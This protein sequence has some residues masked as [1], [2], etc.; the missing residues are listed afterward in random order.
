MSGEFFICLK[1]VNNNKAS[2]VVYIEDDSFL[3]YNLSLISDAQNIP[4]SFGYPN[5]CI[6]IL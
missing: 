3:H 5:K 6:S 2:G 1:F 4:F